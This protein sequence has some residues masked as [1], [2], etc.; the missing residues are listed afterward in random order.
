VADGAPPGSAL[1]AS[2]E[3]VAPQVLAAA[4]QEEK[5]GVVDRLLAHL[6][7]LVRVRDLNGAAGDD[8]QAIVSSIEADCRHGDISGALAAFDK[9][10]EAARK[11]AGD[12]PVKAR[13]RQAADTALQSIRTTAIGQLA[14]GASP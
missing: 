10:P 14:G 13:A 9:L 1:A 2:F 3:A 4:S 12:W 8:P 6:R 5:G 7:G 11:A